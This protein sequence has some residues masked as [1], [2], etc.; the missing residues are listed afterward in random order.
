LERCKPRNRSWA[1]IIQ[2]GRGGGLNEGVRVERA[3][4]SLKY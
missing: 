2:I 4:Q 3:G 1:M